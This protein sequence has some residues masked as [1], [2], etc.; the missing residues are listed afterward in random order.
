MKN[1]GFTL[2]EIV[3]VLVVMGILLLVTLPSVF[4][5]LDKKKNSSHD[6]LIA[7]I[8]SAAKLYISQNKDVRTFLESTQ[9]INIS[10]DVLAKEGLI[11]GSQIDPLTN[12]PLTT[13]S[14]VNVKYNPTTY[15]LTTEYVE[16]TITSTIYLNATPITISTDE[17][18]LNDKLLQNVV[19][20][21]ETGRNFIT[22]VTYSCQINKSGTSTPQNCAN[23]KN[24][25]GTHNITYKIS[26]QEKTVDLTVN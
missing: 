25:P 11:K 6:E 17:M 23:I 14:Y 8:E 2:V 3:A 19:A 13:E 5:T 4:N 16:G 12:E 1:K 15:S 10:Y 20:R 22:A 21:D 7:E 26:N 9:E 18:H 24:N